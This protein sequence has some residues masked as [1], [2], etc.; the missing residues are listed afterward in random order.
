MIPIFG[1]IFS[2]A[3]L[4]WDDVGHK[5]TA[6]IAW[7]QMSPQARAAAA[8]FLQAAPEDSHLSA[9]FMGDARPREVRELEHFMIASTWAD[10]VR[11]RKFKKRYDE[12]H[13]GNW[14]YD[15]TFWTKE[16]GQFKILGN[17]GEEGGKFN[18]YVVDVMADGAG[19]YAAGQPRRLTGDG[20][21]DAASGLSWAR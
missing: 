1:A 2:L 12:F 19:G 4:A 18:V 8:K 6:Y 20:D 5:T 16:N 7:Q 9:L 11:D 21:V 3:V 14:H 15:D 13:K 17:V 10:I